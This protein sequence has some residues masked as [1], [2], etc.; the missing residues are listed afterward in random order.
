M[1]VVYI[2]TL[3]SDLILGDISSFSLSILEIGTSA[4]LVLKLSTSMGLR[5]I[6]YI[7]T[8]L[9]GFVKVGMDPIRFTRGAWVNMSQFS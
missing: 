7:R 2:M 3:T 4:S 1:L 8:S 6:D 5:M 9:L